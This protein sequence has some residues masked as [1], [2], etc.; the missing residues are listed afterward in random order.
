MT[1]VPGAGFVVFLGIAAVAVILPLLAGVSLLLARVAG[2]RLDATLLAVHSLGIVV[3]VFLFASGT[4]PGV[5]SL[6]LSVGA[7]VGFLSSALA[8]GV[9]IAL[10]GEWGPIALGALVTFLLRET[11]YARSVRC[12]TTG[13]VV[14][15]VGGA[16]IGLLVSGTVL[17]AVA[18]AL[19][20][21]PGALLGVAVDVT[22]TRFE[23]SGKPV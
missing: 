9:L 20:S 10:L 13:Y 2:R 6:D 1:N 14:G 12:S 22:A 4:V 19:L 23:T 18:G 15:G 3:G 11:D 7:L 16:V 21:I 8:V 5:Q 17:G